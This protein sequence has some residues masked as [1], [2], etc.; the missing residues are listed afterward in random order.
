M[1]EE[2]LSSLVGSI[3]SSASNLTIDDFFP[4][5]PILIDKCKSLNYMINGEILDLNNDFKVTKYEDSEI[6]RTYKMYLD[7]PYGMQRRLFEEE[8][9]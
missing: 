7:D 2:R 4:M 9:D 1:I 5:K 8:N 6:Y 3:V